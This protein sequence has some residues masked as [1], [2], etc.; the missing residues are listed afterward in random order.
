MRSTSTS[1]FRSS[2]A[3][4]VRRDVS[5]RGSASATPDSYCGD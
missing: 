2:N 4:A 1:D 5:R 3:Y